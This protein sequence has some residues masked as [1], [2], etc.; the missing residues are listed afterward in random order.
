MDSSWFQG[1]PLEFF[2]AFFFSALKLFGVHAPGLC[3]RCLDR[4]L[5]SSFYSLHFWVVERKLRFG[6]ASISSVAGV[7]TSP[8]KHRNSSIYF[9]GHFPRSVVAKSKSP[10]CVLLDLVVA[11]GHSKLHK[12]ASF[13]CMKF[14]ISAVAAGL[15]FRPKIWRHGA[16]QETGRGFQRASW[17]TFSWCKMRMDS[18]M[19]MRY[20][21]WG[22]V[23]QSQIDRWRYRWIFMNVLNMHDI[24]AQTIHSNI[25]AMGLWTGCSK[26][27]V[28]NWVEYKTDTTC[29]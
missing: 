22:S 13:H 21:S 26:C 17:A 5:R 23:S 24:P 28:K 27:W 8:W 11:L 10:S 1:D 19:C 14:S 2:M 15:N 25:C 12:L 3:A 7:G 18:G 29:E 20:F 4:L 16:A 9:H 6:G